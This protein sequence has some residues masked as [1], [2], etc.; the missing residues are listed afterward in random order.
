MC[1][2]F[3][4]QPSWLAPQV[5][6]NPPRQGLGHKTTASTIRARRQLARSADDFAVYTLGLLGLES[7]RD[8]WQELTGNAIAQPAGQLALGFG[9]GT[10]VSPL[11]L[12][13]AYTV[14][15]NAGALREPQAI[16]QVYLDGLEQ[17]FH[18]PPVTP[19]LDANAAYITAEMLRSVV[20]YG[21]DGEFGTARRALTRVG[22]TPQK[23]VIGGK[24]GS[25]PSSVWMVSVSPQLVVTAWL[26]YQC[27]SPIARADELFAAD[28]AAPVWA[29]FLRA[30]NKY[31]PDLLNGDWPAPPAVTPAQIDPRRGCRLPEGQGQ[32]E[33]FLPH[34]EPAP[35]DLK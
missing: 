27:H 8:L 2:G 16:S 25:G 3:C 26:G 17:T 21:P 32:T 19:V 15:A 23:L 35:C 18:R 20:G 22:L 7:G 13:R 14:F 9:A 4:F 28:T 5:F 34:T 6:S 11:R 30:V 12:A 31:R 1:H 10:E 29:E 24:T 33:F